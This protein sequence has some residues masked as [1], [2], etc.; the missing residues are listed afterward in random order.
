MSNPVDLNQVV[1]DYF[2]DIFLGVANNEA[3]YNVIPNTPPI[4][5]EDDNSELTRPFHV[6]EFKEAITSMHADKAPG[7]DGFNPGSYQKFWN[8]VGGGV[9]S[10]CISWLNDEQFL[11]ELYKTNVVLIPMC[12]APTSMKDLRL[13]T[14]CNAIYKILA[15]VLC[16]RLKKTLPSLVDLAQSAFV[17]NRSIQDNIL[18]TFETIHA[19]KNKWRGKIGDV[20][21]KIDISKAYDRVDWGYLEFMLRKLG[22]Y[23]KWVK[24]IM[25]CVKSVSYNFVVNNNIVGP[26]IPS[27]GLRQGDHLSPYLFILCVEGL[28][29]MLC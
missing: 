17:S 29:M 10:A 5:S 2:R 4:M 12:D 26:V 23:M 28:S 3:A 22:F 6:D 24:W 7:P 25:L 21:L 19:M 13:I 1:L 18:I 27:W 20:A 9:A 15:K 16:N 14:L 11:T 8:V